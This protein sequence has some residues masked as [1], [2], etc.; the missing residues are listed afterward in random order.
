MAHNF[1]FGRQSEAALKPYVFERENM[2]QVLLPWGRQDRLEE[3]ANSLFELYNIPFDE[4]VTRVKGAS[5]LIQD[6]RLKLESVMRAVNHEIHSENPPLFHEKEAYEWL[7]ILKTKGTWI[8]LMCGSFKIK[9]GSYQFNVE[10]SLN[11][12][13]LNSSLPMDVVG[14]DESCFLQSGVVL[15]SRKSS[16]FAFQGMGLFGLQQNQFAELK[17]EIQE[18]ISQSSFWILEAV[19]LPETR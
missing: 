17:N 2:I 10:S 8:W 4:D 9:S 16:L 19:E 14:I 3:R 12:E 1:F 15:N 5:P 7:V 11:T 6:P 13:S 18:K